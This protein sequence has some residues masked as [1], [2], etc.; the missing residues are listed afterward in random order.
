MSRYTRIPDSNEAESATKKAV[1]K[2]ALTSLPALLAAMI[3]GAVSSDAD[4]TD[5]S[6]AEARLASHYYVEPEA[7]TELFSV[8]LSAD[9]KTFD[10][11][12]EEG[13][14][15]TV[16]DALESAGVEVGDDDLINIGLNEKL[17]S[18][19]DIVINRVEKQYEVSVQKI[20]YA[21]SYKNDPNYAIG[22][23]EVLVNGREGEVEITELVTYID[24]EEAS[25]EVVNK[26]VTEP[27]D[28]VILSGTCPKTPI[29][30]LTAPDSLQFDANGVPLNYSRVLTGKSCAYS[31]KPGAKTASGR[32][33]MVGYVAVDPAVIPYGTELYIA[34]TDNSAVYGY[35]VAADTGTALLD[36]RIL[37]D[38]FMESYDASCDWGARQVNIYVLN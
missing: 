20:E 36:G 15:A 31:A 26:E 32:T 33:A 34:T 30:Q 28:E 37:V 13:S 5:T 14:D 35:A 23:T 4:M 12:F 24:G 27:V 8:S 7:P 29:S 1:L 21:T 2:I 11:S 22:H 38:L 19:A 6:A 3:F 18:G 16:S 10:L 25:S 17:T 9:G